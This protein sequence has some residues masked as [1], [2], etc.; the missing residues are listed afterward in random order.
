MRTV[1]AVLLLAILALL[2]PARGLHASGGSQSETEK[3]DEL[4][5]WVRDLR[6]GDIIA[7][8][9]FPFTF[10]LAGAIVDTYRASQHGWDT[11]YAPWPVNMGGAVS[12]TTEE[13]LVTISIAAGGAILV[14]V[15]DHIIQRVKRERAAQEAARL[16]PSE[17]VIIRSPWPPEEEDGDGPPK[18]TPLPGIDG[19]AP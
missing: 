3:K 15:A 8:G 6:R 9:S 10:F 12:R 2:F 17:P 5:Q 4:P 16:S 14:A 19:G 1:F 18:E 7:F 11:R 13:H